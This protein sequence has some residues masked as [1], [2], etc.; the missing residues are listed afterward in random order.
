[1]QINK[2]SKNGLNFWSKISRQ[3]GLQ[4]FLNTFLGKQRQKLALYTK[5]GCDPCKLTQIEKKPK[6]LS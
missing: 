3:V 2:D 6:Y 4:I 1:M 5:M